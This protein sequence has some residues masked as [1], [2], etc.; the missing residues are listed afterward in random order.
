MQVKLKNV[1][2]SFANIRKPYVPKTGD[3]KYTFSG[4]CSGDTKIDVTIDGKKLLL[5]H[6]EFSKVLDAVCKDKW[7]KTPAKLEMYAYARA[8]QQVGSR[9]AKINEDGDYYDGYDED[10][11]FFAAG[12]KVADAP[13]GVLIVDQK[14]EPLPAS[15]GHPVNGD[16]VNAI[17]NLFAYEYE[18]KK[19]I[20]ASIEAIQY[21]RKGEPFG[22]AKASAEAF[23]EELE[24]ELDEEESF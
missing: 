6:T 18:G 21:L 14:R 20:S 2:M 11:W 24:E 16:Y 3:Q 12:V 1:R 17:L 10:T 15:A 23:D 7:G 4:I 9:G 22:A 8:D 19:G 5:P 13:D